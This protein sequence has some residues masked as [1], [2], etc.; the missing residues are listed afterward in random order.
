MFF[1]GPDL[2]I[3]A[4]HETDNANTP[5]GEGN[6]AKNEENASLEVPDTT[7]N[8]SPPKSVGFILETD[9][10]NEE[11]DDIDAEIDDALDEG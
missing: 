2:W 1:L 5:A 9:V 4:K 8:A 6:E 10:V 11:A 7:V 3:M